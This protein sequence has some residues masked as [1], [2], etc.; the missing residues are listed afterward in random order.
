MI[1]NILVGNGINI[2]FGG[3]EYTNKGILM[4]LTNNLQTIDYS[5][6]FGNRVTNN[7]LL[8]LVENLCGLIPEILK[9]KYDCFCNSDD[10]RDVLARFKK[11]YKGNPQ[12]ED[13]AMEDYFFILLLFH[14]RFGDKQ[15]L[16]TETYQGFCYLFLD[17]IY[18]T[19]RIQ[20][21]YHSISPK[22]IQDLKSKFAEYD[23]VFTVN[24]D[25]NLEKIAKKRVEYLHGDFNTLWD[26]Y[27]PTTL[28]GA[29]RVE[30][31]AKNPVNDDNRHMYCNAIMGFVGTEKDRIIQMFNNLSVGVNGVQKKLLEGL[32]Q[33]EIDRIEQIEK[34]SNKGD[35]F[36]YK[37]IE[38]A[39]KNPKLSVHTYPSDL[40]RRING[41]LTIIGMSPQND[42]HIWKMIEDNANIKKIIYYFKD[43]SDKDIVEKRYSK[44]HVFTKPV[45]EF[46]EA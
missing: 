35:Q 3:C 36:A 15:E 5:E 34:S 22:T 11:Q 14:K 25:C 30:K 33:Q 7:E 23:N 28:S 13:I 39:T 37:L 12:T 16:I 24:Y 4:R 41:E 40:F 27:D 17:A 20:E 1:K 43:I 9:G 31:G 45:Y 32:S 21:I 26:E 10:E 6:I 42:E 46:W 18:N 44:L 29:M 38:T 8:F 2:Q 19:G